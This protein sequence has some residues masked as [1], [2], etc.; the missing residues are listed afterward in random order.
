ME[1]FQPNIKDFKPYIRYDN[2]GE[3]NINLKVSLMAENVEGK[4]ILIHE[5]IKEI[6][7]AYR[8]SGI[9]IAYPQRDIHMK[10]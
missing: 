10:K 2:F 5:F 4:F 3:S 1:K 6:M 7:K 8:K 9:E